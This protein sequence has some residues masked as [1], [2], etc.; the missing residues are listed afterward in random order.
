MTV[1]PY[2][3]GLRLAGRRVVVVG[4]GAV[5]TRR[6]PALL[7]AGADVFLV[8]PELT[9]ALHAH[10]DAGRVHWAPRRFVPD[11]LD[12][13]WL[14]QVAVDD[15]L[16][17]A[18]VSAA[19]AERKI[20]C[21]RADDRAAATAWTPA[22]TRHGPVTVAVLGGGDPRRAMSVRD[23]VRDLLNVRTGLAAVAPQ[24]PTGAAPGRVALVGAGPGDPELIT[25]KGWRLLTEADVV[26]A[27]RLVPGLLLDELRPDVE[28]VD[29]SKIPYGPSRAQEEINRIL[30][31][32]ALAGRFVVR[33]KGG[34]PYVF[35][36][37]GEELLACAEAGVP[38]TV[39]P[40]VTSAIAVPAVAGVPVTHRAVAHEFTV[41]SGHVAPDSPASLVQ[42]P[43]LA[44]LRGTLVVLM[45]LKNLAAIA[46]TLTGHGKDP[47]TRVA[48]IQEGTTGAQRSLRSTL[49][50]VAADVVAAGLRP[51][52]IVVIGSVVGALDT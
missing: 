8:A 4:G 48:V 36:R 39:V 30:V 41:V 52:A 7:D 20:F 29:A 18:S 23:A 28:L 26:V 51:P 46:D 15:P 33:L 6:V 42:W 3:L 40:G 35:G 44:G 32:R 49:G 11:D 16:A 22:V 38:V 27:D 14:V 2:P 17:A 1:N 31:E 9:P 10:V 50:T 43:A 34:D 13:A 12:G 25:V 5:A 47:A 24:A 45:G 19:A 37:G 21:V